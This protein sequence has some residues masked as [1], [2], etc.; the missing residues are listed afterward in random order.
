MVAGGACTREVADKVRE[1][2]R[3]SGGDGGRVCKVWETNNEGE[4]V[5]EGA[6]RSIAM[7][8]TCVITSTITTAP[9]ESQQ[10]LGLPCEL[11]VIISN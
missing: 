7:L 1:V 6:V 9:S 10:T 11:G 5:S 3:Y 2:A 4:V 8:C